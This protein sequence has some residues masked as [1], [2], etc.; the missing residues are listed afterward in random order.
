[1]ENIKD[2]SAAWDL[3]ISPRNSF[4]D[5][6]F[7]ELW[8]YRDLVSFFVKRDFTSQYKQTILGP[9]WFFIQPVLTAITFTVIFGNV[10]NIPTDG[11]PSFLFFLSGTIGWNYFADCLNKTSNTFVLNAQIFGKVYFPRLIVPISIIVSNLIK[12]LVQFAI[13]IIALGYYYFKSAPVTPNIHMLLTPFLLFLMAGLGLGFG[14]IITSL[15]TKYRDLQFLISFAVQLLMYATPVVYPLSYVPEKYKL[16]VCLNPMTSVVEAFRY[17]YL[18]AGG[19]DSIWLIYS[20]VFTFCL[21][22]IGVL[23]FNKVEKSFMDNV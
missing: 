14:I 23:V 13:F 11:V 7:K 22:I 20:T 12:F 21:L 1:M 10:A 19:I 16:L 5:I 15:T 2:E 6:N 4:F 8:R 18:G 9:L 17:A 3:E